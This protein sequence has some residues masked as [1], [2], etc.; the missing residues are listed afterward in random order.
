MQQSYVGNGQNNRY[1]L[2]Q[3][4]GI[5]PAQPADQQLSHGQQPAEQGR[6]QISSQINTVRVPSQ[7]GSQQPVIIT[8]GNG[9]TKKKSSSV[10]EV[11]MTILAI[12]LIIGIVVLAVRSFKDQY[13]E[14]QN[15][16]TAEEESAKQQQ[17]Q[18]LETA[19]TK[20]IP[21]VKQDAPEILTDTSASTLHSYDTPSQPVNNSAADLSL[22]SV[23]QS[24]SQSPS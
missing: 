7:V 11:I 13:K 20:D 8:Q 21:E 10:L 6:Q 3:P 23:S 16:K 24:Q 4:Y 1:P 15:Q 2:Q 22:N 5:P 18:Q 14:A 9:K 12:A 17:E 19:S